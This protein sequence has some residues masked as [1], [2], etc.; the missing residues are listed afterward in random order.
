MNDYIDVVYYINL[1]HRQDRKEQFLQEMA[2]AGISEDKIVRV[3]AIY[4]EFKGDLGCSQSHTKAM[5]LYA[6]SSHKTG[7]IFE[8]DFK[9]VL[10]RE[11]I[12]D[13]FHR[14]FEGSVDYDVCLLS[15]NLFGNPLIPVEGCDFIQTITK[16]STLSGY[17]VNKSFAPTLFQNFKEGAELLFKSYEMGKHDPTSYAVDCYSRNL[18]PSGRW[19]LFQPKLGLQRGSWSDIQRN[20]EDYGL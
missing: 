11:Q 14:F 12:D 20:W 3:P 5:E 15:A 1:D 7:I 10:N 18:Q 9:F 8:D 16:S 4:N 17:M 13:Q 6:N 2:I 19:K